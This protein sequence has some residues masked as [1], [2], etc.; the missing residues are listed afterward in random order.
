ML[1]WNSRTTRRQCVV[2]SDF[3]GKK[4][5]F[6]FICSFYCHIHSHLLFIYTLLSEEW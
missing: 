4:A 1:R 5:K 2:P 3:R 6:V